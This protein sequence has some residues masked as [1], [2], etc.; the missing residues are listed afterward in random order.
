[1][2][3]RNAR[4]TR[5]SVLLAGGWTAIALALPDWEL[6]AAALHHAPP[7]VPQV[8]PPLLDPAEIADLEAIT[9]QIVPTDTTPGA[10]EAGTA[11]FIDRALASFF[12]PLAAEFRAGLEEFQRGVRTRYPQSASFAALSQPQQIEW[13]RS[14]EH[15]S[16]FAAVRQLTVLGMFSSPSYGGNRDGIGWKLLGFRDEHAFAPPFGY[17]DR[18]YPGFHPYDGSTP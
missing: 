3:K 10:R 7:N 8:G 2:S 1:M 9:A 14:I 11:R 5:R 4:T 6:L 17:Y 15:S 13:L 16:F 12:A 18:D